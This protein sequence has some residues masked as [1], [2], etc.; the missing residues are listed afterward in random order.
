VSK[1]G[2]VDQLNILAGT[3]LEV[4]LGLTAVNPA[5][6]LLYFGTAPNYGA[7]PMISVVNVTSSSLVSNEEIQGMVTS[8]WVYSQ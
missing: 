4:Y 3:G 1:T 8:A 7:A 5:A 2:V 6:N